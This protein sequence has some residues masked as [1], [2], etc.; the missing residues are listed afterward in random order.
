MKELKCK[1]YK[2]EGYRY[3]L[4]D[5]EAINLCDCCNMNLAGEIMK[6]LALETFG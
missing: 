6:Q 5:K 2:G 1:H 4:S 3:E